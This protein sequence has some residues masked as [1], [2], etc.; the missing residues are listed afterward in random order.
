MPP[1]TSP[2][3][4]ATGAMYGVLNMLRKLIATSS[5][6]KVAVVFDPKGKTFRNDIY[7]EYK[8]NRPSDAG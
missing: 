4:H 5:R 3:G 8:A 6:T 2:T 1:L 7:P